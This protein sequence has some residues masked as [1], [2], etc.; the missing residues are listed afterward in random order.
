MLAHAVQRHRLYPTSSP[1]CLESVQACVSALEAL[2]EDVVQLRVSPGRIFHG[3]DAVPENAVVLE[4]TER[5]FRA[6]V[7]ELSLGRETSLKEL[8]RF[9]RQLATWDRRRDPYESFAETLGE[10]GVSSIRVRSANKLEVLDLEILT[11]ERLEQ[12]EEERSAR[13]PEDQRIE[14][15]ARHE[16]WV[17]VDTDCDVDS[18]DLVDLAF[19]LDNQG[20]L[21]RVLHDIAEG[22]P[23]TASAADA[24][25]ESV[26]EL[27]ELYSSL[28]PRIAEQRFGD[29]AITLMTMDERARN[30]LTRGVLLPDLLE[31][32]KAARLLRLL[33]QEELVAALHTL[34][35]LEVG[36]PGLVKLA[37]DRLA[38]P[39]D[40]RRSLADAIERSL[41]GGHLG[42]DD[43][44]DPPQLLADAA[45][46]DL[47]GYTA[48]QLAVDDETA[49]EL[50]RIK[51]VAE[52]PDEAAERLRCCSNLVRY[53]RN[54]DYAEEI[55]ASA[56][57]LLAA[58]MVDGSE[59]VAAWIEEFR[60]AAESVREVRPEVAELV[61]RMMLALC[62][63][64]FLRAQAE[65]WGDDASMA[66]SHRLLSAFGPASV[67]TL[68][69]LLDEEEA[70]GVRRRLVDFMCEHAD[71]FA[72][73]LRH[74]LD[75]ERWTVVRNVVRMIGFAG[76]GYESDLIPLVRHPEERVAKEALLALARIG[77]QEAI[78]LIAD[79]LGDRDP[80]RRALAEE[81]IRTLPVEE[82]RRQVQRLLRDPGFFR[83]YPRLAR[84]LV[85][86]FAPSGG[87]DWE[88]V[89]RPML[90]VRFRFWQP[91]LMALGWAAAA[92][93][94]EVRK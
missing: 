22:G 49:A 62:S 40:R 38:L 67:E 42:L 19:L 72:P 28:S 92:G 24:L 91:R 51:S 83:R 79:L 80:C 34:A 8:S 4:F 30:A 82:G 93:M 59:R 65:T 53:L 58:A 81:S 52:N 36:A 47:Q 2:S 55:L 84:S 50:S 6:D 29:L 17:Q 15:E 64:E 41:R 1:L 7:E 68:I 11:A 63:P 27:I 46:H 21:A 16:A 44:A 45:G 61:D 73:E 76:Q 87:A 78:D 54:P 5:L 94:R 32:G 88:D 35:D 57:E 23:Q 20:E 25:R 31:T 43:G 39:D 86:R 48:H 12:L 90:D 9:C 69:R 13:A 60:A 37:L 77:S 33:P 3:S 74:Y 56:E 75:D 10:Q 89:L 26:A 71:E 18:I 85:R 14:G 70:R 66:R